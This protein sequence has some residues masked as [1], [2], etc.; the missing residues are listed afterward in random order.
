MGLPANYVAPTGF[1]WMTQKGYPR[2]IAISK[3][4][5]KNPQVW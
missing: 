4:Y 3:K 5:K 1:A 2:G